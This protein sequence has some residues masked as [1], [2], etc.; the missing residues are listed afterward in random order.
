MVNAKA[1]KNHRDLC[2]GFTL[3]ELLVVIA[4]VAILTALL[5][6]VAASHRASVKRTKCASNLRQIG[7]ATMAYVS[8]ND[9]KLPVVA[10]NNLG[11]HNSTRPGLIDLLG[12]YT[13]GDWKIFYCTDGLV[14]YAEQSQRA[15]LAVPNNRFHEIGYYWLQSDDRPF[16]V[17]VDRGPRLAALS[18]TRGILAMCLHFTGYPVHQ[19]KLNVLFA[20][21]HTE[22]RKGDPRGNLLSY[23]NGANFELATEF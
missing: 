16:F 4:I 18:P 22:L 21:G 3:T 8:E 7:V 13:S 14:T 2:C 6:P 12:D 11:R 10:I 20:D 1:P 23:V 9:G 15:D 5:M 17:P 19:N